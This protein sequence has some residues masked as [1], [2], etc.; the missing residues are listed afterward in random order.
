MQD[1][2]KCNVN[3]AI[4]RVSISGIETDYKIIHLLIDCTPQ[5]S[6]L[7]MLKT[8]NVLSKI[9]IQRIHRLKEETMG[10][11]SLESILFCCNG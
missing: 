11:S 1:K 7:K 9:I 5:H 8:L 2:K 6:I 4:V 3:I 10:R